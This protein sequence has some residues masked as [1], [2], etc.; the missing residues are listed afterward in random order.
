MSVPDV[1]CYPKT[2]SF[3]P[4]INLSADHETGLA[5]PKQ[6]K[7]RR[8]ENPR[9]EEPAKK[10]APRQSGRVI[11]PSDADDTIDAYLASTPLR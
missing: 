1:A 10:A 2:G 3:Q 6:T 9:E 11:A 7:I 5:E 8:K 4:S